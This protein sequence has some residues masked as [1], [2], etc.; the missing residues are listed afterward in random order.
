M[1]PCPHKLSRTGGDRF[2]VPSTDRLWGRGAAVPGA[3]PPRSGGLSSVLLAQSLVNARGQAAWD[4]LLMG[5][6][7]GL[8]SGDPNGAPLGHE[9]LWSAP[10]ANPLH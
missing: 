1:S 8:S 5:E 4:H 3:A 10:P 7:V 2:S 6:T 9:S